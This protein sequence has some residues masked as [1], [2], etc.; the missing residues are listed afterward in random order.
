MRKL[1][2]AEK[3]SDLSTDDTE[4]ERRKRQQRAKVNY[5]DDEEDDDDDPPPPKRGKVLQKCKARPKGHAALNDISTRTLNRSITPITS[6]DI[7]LAGN[8]YI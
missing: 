1:K 6:I 7:H 5:S 4:T 2:E 8:L 3:H